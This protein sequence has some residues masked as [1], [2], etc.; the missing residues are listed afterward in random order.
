MRLTPAHHHHLEAERVIKQFNEHM[1]TGCRPDQLDWLP[2]LP[3]I[4]AS[5]NN[6]PSG[7]M[8]DRSPF[9]EPSDR[10][11]VILRLQ[12]YPFMM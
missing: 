9:L 6:Q 4:E 3:S 5:I 12:I 11:A 10:A 8:G 1:R 7:L 2:M